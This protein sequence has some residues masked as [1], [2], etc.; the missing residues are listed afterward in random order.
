MAQIRTMDRDEFLKR[1]SE[2]TDWEYHRTGP[3][4]GTKQVRKP[5]PKLNEDSD[6]D[7]DDEDIPAKEIDNTK[8]LPIK[9]LKIK[10]EEKPCDDCGRIC[11]GRRV[12]IKLSQSGNPHWRRYCSECKKYCDPRNGTYTLNSTESNN[13]HNTYYKCQGI[14]N[15]KQHPKEETHPLDNVEVPEEKRQEILAFLMAKKRTA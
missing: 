8:T 1:L 11:Q 3:N 6:E 14:Y 4:G 15:T 9:I 5:K 7:E 12:E 13:I 2:L 10:F